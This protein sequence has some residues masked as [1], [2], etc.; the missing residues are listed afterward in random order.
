MSLQ[1]RG[2]CGVCGESNAYRLTHCH[3]CGAVLAWGFLLD[4]V[5]DDSGQKKP[6]LWER[7]THQDEKSKSEHLVLCRFCEAP[8]FWDAKVCFRCRRLL[9]SAPPIGA[10]S[11]FDSDAPALRPLIDAYI[12]RKIGVPSE[13]CED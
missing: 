2:C 6:S 12:A 9:V 11:L 3:H 4:E 1:N 5:L 7:L 10:T 8:I 13:D